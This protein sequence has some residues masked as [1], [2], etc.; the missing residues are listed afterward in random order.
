MGIPMSVLPQIKSS[1][2]IY[3]KIASGPL[4]GIPIAGVRYFKENSQKFLKI[5]L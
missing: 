3:G 4:Q 1:A 2:E 5:F